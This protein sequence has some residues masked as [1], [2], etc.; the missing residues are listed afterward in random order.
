VPVRWNGKR[1]ARQG[2]R[3]VIADVQGLQRWNAGK[4]TN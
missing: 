4:S 1:V 2:A 3:P